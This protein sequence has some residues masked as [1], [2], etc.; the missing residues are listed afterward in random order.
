MKRSII[1]LAA[2]LF[3]GTAQAQR[4]AREAKTELDS[5]MHYAIRHAQS[6]AWGYA[7]AN[8][9]EMSRMPLLG[10]KALI[11]YDGNG[12][13][14]ATIKQ[15]EFLVGEVFTAFEHHWML[16]QARSILGAYIIPAGSFDLTVPRSGSVIKRT[17]ES[18]TYDVDSLT[19]NF[20][21]GKYYTIY[22]AIDSE[23]R[24]EFD[25]RE[26]STA[27]YA[28]FMQADLGRLAGTWSMEN[29][30][31]RGQFTNRVAFDGDRMRYEGIVPGT[32]WDFVAEGT[33]IYNENTIIMFPETA[34]VNGKDRMKTFGG[35][36]HIW[37][38]TLT[39]GRLTI[40]DDMPRVGG[41]GA[42]GTFDKTE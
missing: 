12:L 21:P 27:D 42:N 6:V 19:F 34:T 38:Y 14:D 36:P 40:D 7:G 41:W 5:V 37:Y 32:R 1:I 4:A 8:G 23:D 3:A 10:E 25:I 24:I 20:E 2:V 11:T 28:D 17:E 31:I 29:K 18:V 9:I 39:D 22:S 16:L 26:I 13:L 30:T 15:R 33:F 35:E